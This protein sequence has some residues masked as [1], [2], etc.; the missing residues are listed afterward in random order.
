[1]KF[2]LW[3]TGKVRPPCLENL[4]LYNFILRVIAKITGDCNAPR[5]FFLSPAVKL[6]V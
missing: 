4:Y 6:G 1:M 5:G 3:K 2:T